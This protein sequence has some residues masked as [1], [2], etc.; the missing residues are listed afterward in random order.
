MTILSKGLVQIYTGNGKGKT[1]AAFGLAWRMLGSGGRV[2]ICQFLKPADRKTGESALAQCFAENLLLEHLD[3]P[4]NMYAADTDT[5][6]NV[7]TQAAIAEKLSQIR[8]LAHQGLYDLMILD[9]IVFCL[10]KKIAHLKDVCAVINSRAP[11]VELVLTGRGAEDDLI[12]HA[13]LVTCMQEIKHPYQN[14]IPAR[15]GIEY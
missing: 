14:N 8:K 2:Y 9:E 10:S 12:A 1:T 15:P 7:R 3:T 13:D 11:H 5:T 6:Q 4:W